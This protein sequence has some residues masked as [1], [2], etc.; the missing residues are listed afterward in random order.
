MHGD[1]AVLC[2]CNSSTPEFG[3]RLLKVGGQSGIGDPTSHGWLSVC[4][5]ISFSLYKE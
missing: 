1:A 3:A 4:G 5:V 2:A